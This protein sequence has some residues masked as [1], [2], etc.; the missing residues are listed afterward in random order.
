[1]HFKGIT[2]EDVYWTY[3]KRTGYTAFLDEFTLRVQAGKLNSQG[4]CAWDWLVECAGKDL[5]GENNYKF[6]DDAMKA[7]IS[8]AK[9]IYT[10]DLR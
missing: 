8:F 10:R 5:E 3:D 6:R 9:S 4:G 2:V 7:A 1:M